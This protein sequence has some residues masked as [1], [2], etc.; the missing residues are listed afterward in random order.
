MQKFIIVTPAVL[1]DDTP[2]PL[3][4]NVE[5]IAY[6]RESDEFDVGNTILHLK[7]GR[8]LWVRQT[9]VEIKNLIYPI[10]PRGPRKW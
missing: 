7:T 6:Y 2:E 10:K 3:H 9:V 5:A 8:D 1:L 4:L